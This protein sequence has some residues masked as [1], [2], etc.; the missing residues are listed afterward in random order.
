MGGSANLKSA[1]SFLPGPQVIYPVGLNRTNK[2]VTTTLPEQLHSGASIITYEHP[3]MWIDIPPPPLEELGC[4]TLLF[5]EANTI[6]TTNSPKPPPKPRISMPTEVNN[7]LTEVMAGESSHESEHS[8]IG[9]AITVEA[10]TFPP[11]KSEASPPP[12][13]TSSQA[14]MEE[15]KASL[16]CLPAYISPITAACSSSSASPSVDPTELQADVNMAANHMLHVK[17][18]TDLKRQHVIWELGLLMHQSEVDEAASIKKA[19]VIHSQEVLDARVDCARLVLKAKS[20]Y[21][22]AVQKAKMIR[23]NL[24]QK[25]EIVYSKAINEAM[26]LRLSQLVALHR[27]QIQLMQEL[28]EQALREESKSHHDFLS[29]Y[30]TALHPSPQTLKE[31]LATSYHTLLGYS[32]PSP[33]SVQ[34][35]R[36][37]P[38]EE[39]P[40]VAV[41][42]PPVPKQSPQPKRQ[43]P[44]PEPQGSTSRD[45]TTSRAMQEGPSSPKKHEAPVWFTTLKPSCTEAFLLDSSIVQDA[46]ACFF[47]KHS[48]SFV[49]DGTCDLS[50]VVK[51]LV[52]STGLLG[53]AIYEI[54]LSWTGPQELKQANYA[55]WSLPKRAKIPKGSACLRVSKGHGPHG[56]S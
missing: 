41:S 30:Q 39:Q 4:P 2:P 19:K 22:A 16:K 47:S 15:V 21:Q 38:E 3:Y 20:N 14:S 17:R 42:P 37:P 31:N 45:D 34:L 25:S 5:D 26:T 29:A 28:E 53:E 13:D 7:L 8:P 6:A 32:P 9:K 35:A 10:V 55:L 54:Q 40:P 49:N 44:M 33:P 51:G 36:A 24:P 48:Y 52:K 46:R 11:H 18:S 56:Y 12:V 1:S 43:L 27:E 50:D 23:Y